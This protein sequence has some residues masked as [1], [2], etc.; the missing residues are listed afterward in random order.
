MQEDPKIKEFLESLIDK[1]AEQEQWF[2]NLPADQENLLK[3]IFSLSLKEN[4]QYYF[5]DCQI[6]NKMNNPWNELLE[7]LDLKTIMHLIICLGPVN[8]RQSIASNAN[9]EQL[10]VLVEAVESANSS[11]LLNLMMQIAES[12]TARSFQGDKIVQALCQYFGEAK[13]EQ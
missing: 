4:L 9:L 1:L 3:A 11:G 6:E 10:L 2:E 13:S 8:F 12:Q 7:M 5:E